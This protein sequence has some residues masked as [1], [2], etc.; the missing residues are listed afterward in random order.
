V[1]NGKEETN[2]KGLRASVTISSLIIMA[3]MLCRSNAQATWVFIKSSTIS[4]RSGG[5]QTVTASYSDYGILGLTAPYGITTKVNS[6]LVSQCPNGELTNVQTELS[7]RNFLLVQLYNVT[8]T[9]ICH[10]APPPP[11]PAPQPPPPAAQKIILRGVH[12]AFNKAVIRDVDKPVLDE[13]VEALKSTP[14]VN[15]DVNG[16]TDAIGSASYNKRLSVR[17]AR[18]VAGYLEAQ[19]IPATHLTVQGFG[20]TNFVATNRTAEGRAQNRRV[21]LVPVNQ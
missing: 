17:R 21:E 7:M 15:I 14:N 1:G 19:G 4:D 3:T 18:A 8:A 13:S 11:P 16:Y 20:K 2:M 10:V 12:F 5:G 6:Q 9:A